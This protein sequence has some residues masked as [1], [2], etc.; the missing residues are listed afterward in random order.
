M[1]RL[2]QSMRKLCLMLGWSVSVDTN[3]KSFPNLKACALLRIRIGI[4]S[5]GVIGGIIG[6]KNM[7]F[8]IW[9]DTVNIASRIE[10]AGLNNKINTSMQTHDLI[11]ENYDCRYRDKIEV[12][13]IG[14]LDLYW[15]EAK[16]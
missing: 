15:I 16:K 9:G 13:G 5:G 6:S 11:K 14:T 12:K 10:S 8:V 4:H 2:L 7:S 3:R 1:N